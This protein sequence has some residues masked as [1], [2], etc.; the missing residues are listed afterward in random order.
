MPQVTIHYTEIIPM[1]RYASK[2]FTVELSD[3]VPDSPSIPRCTQT[4]FKI[5]RE[6]VHAQITVA[7]IPAASSAT[8]PESPSNSQPAVNIPA[9]H[10]ATPKQISCIFAI[11][12]SLHLSKEE[13][14]GMAGCHIST[15]ELTSKDASK[16]IEYLK[17][18]QAA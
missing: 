8:A 17:Q 1:E 11:G 14:E 9:E 6:Q 13:L 5:A 7:K 4:L 15:R 16:V 2:H 3:Q 10:P 12:Q 18:K